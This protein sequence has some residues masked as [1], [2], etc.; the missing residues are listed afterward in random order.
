MQ[1]LIN[2][3]ERGLVPDSVTRLGIRALLKARLDEVST[4]GCEGWHARKRTFV[5]E[6]RSSPVAIHTD[7]ANAQHYEVPAAFFAAVLGPHLKYSSGLWSDGVTTLRASEEAMLKLTCEHAGIE[8]GMTVLDLGCGWGSLSLWIARRFPACRVLSVSNSSQQRRYIEHRISDLGLDNVAVRTADMNNFV[9]RSTFDRIVTVEMFEHM[10]NW[11]ELYRRIADWL[12]PG[13]VMLQHVFCHREHAYPYLS[14]G[15]ED[16]MA[17]HFFTGGM[18]PS[19]D[20]PYR[21]QDHLAVT[22]HWRINGIHYSKTLEA[23]L[24]T[25]D[26]N[27]HEVLDLFRAAYGSQAPV[28]FV[29]WRLFFMACSELFRYRGGN[30]WWVSHYRLEHAAAGR[31]QPTDLRPRLVTADG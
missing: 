14:T 25:M 3:A 31:A 1:T 28:W 5:D 13:G 29:R 6:L 30:E 24:A 2:L 9:P 4:G 20:L 7:D 27:R 17:E 11:P 12:K 19:D 26:E 18:M 15:P 10:R 23:W 21:F 22:D 8:D 16:W